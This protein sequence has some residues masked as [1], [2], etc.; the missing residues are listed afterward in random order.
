MRANPRSPR[1]R[2][3]RHDLLGRRWRLA[4]LDLHLPGHAER[5]LT[6]PAPRQGLCSSGRVVWSQDDGR[7]S[8]QCSP[9]TVAAASVAACTVFWA[10]G[11]LAEGCRSAAG[12][13]GGYSVLDEPVSSTI[14]TTGSTSSTAWWPDAAP[15][16]QHPMS[17]RSRTAG[18]AGDPSPAARPSASSTCAD[19]PTST[20]A[21]RSTPSPGDPPGRARR[22][23]PPANASNSTR[24]RSSAPGSTPETQL[25]T[26]ITNRPTR[27]ANKALRARQQRPVRR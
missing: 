6:V 11:D 14:H 25:P 10:V 15:S 4:R 26:M 12:P 17:R 20:R 18:A 19:R 7:N 13:P 22:T 1:R 21:R 8:R 27:R 24:T 5:G 2:P 9:D 16:L 23:P 3:L